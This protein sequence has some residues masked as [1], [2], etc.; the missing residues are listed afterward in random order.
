MAVG[1]VGFKNHPGKNLQPPPRLI[2]AS[3]QKCKQRF[4]Q[5]TGKAAA[6]AAEI[7]EHLQAQQYIFV[8]N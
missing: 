4:H 8:P 1:P 6:A 7:H 3:D 2:D 5:F